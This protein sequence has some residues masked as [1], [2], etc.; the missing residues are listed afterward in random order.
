L[1][2]ERKRIIKNDIKFRVIGDIE[3]LP[4]ETKNLI[5]SLE[6]ETCNN[7]GLK[8]C[9]AFGY[10]SKNEITSSVNKWIRNN[11]GEEISEEKI[12][13][14]LLTFENGPVDLMIRT[15]GDKRLS[16][17]LL[18]Q[19]AYAELFFS[20]T[21][22]PDFTREEFFKIL[23]KF[24]SIERRFGKLVQESMRGSTHSTNEEKVFN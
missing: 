18:W 16:N 10:G 8:L 14:N 11:P 5:S 23:D 9:I 22:W 19:C 4:K 13:N 7:Q 15:G 12:N 1:K 17:F 2:K 20:K 3:S 21:K 24:S 6:D